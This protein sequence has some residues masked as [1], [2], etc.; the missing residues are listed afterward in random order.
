MDLQGHN[1][2]IENPLGAIT[3]TLYAVEIWEYISQPNV[4][5]KRGERRGEIFAPLKVYTAW[6]VGCKHDIDLHRLPT[7]VQVCHCFKIPLVLQLRVQNSNFFS[8]GMTL[9]R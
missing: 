1:L 8:L 4:P 7:G 5:E 3:Y 9:C 2:D 6:P